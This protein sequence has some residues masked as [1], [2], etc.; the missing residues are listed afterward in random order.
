MKYWGCTHNPLPASQL[1]F[2][3]DQQIPEPLKR[4]HGRAQPVEVDLIQAEGLVPALL[5]VEDGLEDGGEWSDSDTSPHQE[6]N[7]MGEH[8]LAGSAERSVDGNPVVMD[9]TNDTIN[10]IL[11]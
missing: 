1:A 5:T 10:S 3:V 8:I 6:T 4:V 2:N 11:R 9:D 7:L